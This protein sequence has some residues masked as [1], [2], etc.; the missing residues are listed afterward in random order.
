VA[1]VARFLADKSALARLHRP[2]V[3]AQLGPLIEVGLVATCAM[4][5]F[6]L[7]WSTRSASEFDELRAD[8]RLGY[9]WLPTEDT[10]W[11]RALEVQRQLWVDGLIRSVP[12]P[13]LL[14]AAVA[15]A[16]ELTVIH[17][18]ADYDKIA[19]MT[20]QSTEWV[21]PPGTVP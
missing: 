20:G 17:Y 13:D 3:F 7:L 8:R 6:E 21:V 1:A 18:D 9:E 11:R 16:N 5:D 12:L 4:I 14:I 2:T 19:S 10:H 15:E